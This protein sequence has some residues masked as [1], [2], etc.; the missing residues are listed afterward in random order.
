MDKHSNYLRGQVL[1]KLT[2]NEYETELDIWMRG[3]GNAMRNVESSTTCNWDGS[4]CYFARILPHIDSI[5]E[6]AG[7]VAGGQEIIIEGNGFKRAKNV[8]VLV[9]EVPCKVTEVDEQ[10]VK[11]ETGAKDRADPALLYYPGEHGVYRTWA[12][13][14]LNAGNYMNHPTNRTLLT[15]AEY[16]PEY[17]KSERFSLM[18]GFYEAPTDGEYQFH[19]TCDDVC[20]LWM[21]L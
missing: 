7:S 11:C 14:G 10:G 8:E 17:P 21:S 19:M 20:S 5:S 12:N 16:A 6:T 2:T 1:S 4:E 13:S 9:D 18:Q 15:H 3:A